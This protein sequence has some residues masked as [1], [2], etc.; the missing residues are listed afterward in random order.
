MCLPGDAP[1]DG[2]TMKEIETDA[3]NCTWH[4]EWIHL[5]YDFFVYT[6]FFGLYY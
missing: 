6:F 4:E 5:F 1:V 3:S 2:L